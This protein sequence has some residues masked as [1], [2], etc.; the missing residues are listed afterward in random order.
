MIQWSWNEPIKENDGIWLAGHNDWPM[1][2]YLTRLSLWSNFSCLWVGTW[3]GKYIN[4]FHS[5][6]DIANIG[7][8]PNRGWGM[9]EDTLITN[10]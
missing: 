10:V 3:D 7:R 6:Y 9:D 2:Q 1:W 4:Y 5:M 8:G